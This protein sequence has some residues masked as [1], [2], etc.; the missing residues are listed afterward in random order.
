M[1]SLVK[2]KPLALN[3][4]KVSP[5][6]LEHGTSLTGQDAHQIQKG[7]PPS[8]RGALPPSLRAKAALWQQHF[9]SAKG[10]PGFPTVSGCWSRCTHNLSDNSLRLRLLL[11]KASFS[12]QSI[13]YIL[14]GGWNSTPVL[15]KRDKQEYCTGQKK[16]RKELT[17]YSSY[18]TSGLERIVERLSSHMEKQWNTQ[19]WFFIPFFSLDIHTKIPERKL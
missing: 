3:Y 14:N 1:S 18:S 8:D 11:F 16:R 10:G 6:N 12:K 5:I 4:F 19:H 13:I 17:V 9:S 15:R 2:T 7:Q